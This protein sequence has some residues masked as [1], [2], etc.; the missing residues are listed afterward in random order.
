MQI[1]PV[2]YNYANR[3]IQTNNNK[4]SFG[5]KQIV[6]NDD[7]RAALSQIPGLNGE[8]IEEIMERSRL[9]PDIELLGLVNTAIKTATKNSDSHGIAK[10]VFEF[11]DE[12]V[13]SKR[14]CD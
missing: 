12:Y 6:S 4:T 2:S 14:F 9:L 8:H 10:R 13:N 11:I 3:K 1:T 5:T 7:L